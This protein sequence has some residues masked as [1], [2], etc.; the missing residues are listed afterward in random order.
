MPTAILQFLVAAGVI[1]A[2]G[3]VL[4][5]CADAIAELTGL[6]RMLVGMVLI[7][8]ATSLPELAVDVSAMR[9]GIPNLGVGD[10]LGS[11]LYN[12]LILA[13]LDL[14]HRGRGGMLSRT[15]AAHALSATMSIALTAMAGMAVLLGPRWPQASFA[16]IGVS[17]W[18]I[19]VVFVLGVR[20]VFFDQKLAAE[21][22]E[23]RRPSAEA[24]AR[25]LSLSRALIGY[26]ATA[27]V[28]L[29]A[30]P[31]LAEAAG[32]IAELSGLGESFVGTAFVALSTSLPELSTSLTALRMKAYDLILG[33]IL[34]SNSFNM[35]LFAA[36]DLAYPGPLFAAVSPANAVTALAVV[37]VT[38]VVI[39]G[40]LY[41]AERRVR[42]IEP[43]ALL[44]VALVIGSLALNFFLR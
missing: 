2:A 39:A 10:L 8:A 43:D 24:A 11:S 38:T 14:L 16:G 19:V 15:S 26:V 22:L 23:Q 21:K 12:L 29:V 4:T 42:F 17:A 41:H 44:V 36:L 31:Y 9:M 20:I 1:V 32:R 7:A 5:R 33:N 37:L 25:R 3:V 34:G 18:A 35:T 6:G 13:V 27:A 30:G 28:I 40:Q